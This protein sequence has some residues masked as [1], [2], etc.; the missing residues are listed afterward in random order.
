VQLY[1][2]KNSIQIHGGPVCCTTN[3]LPITPDLRLSTGNRLYQQLCDLVCLLSS[4]QTGT[5]LKFCKHAEPEYAWVARHTWQSWRE[6]YKKNAARLDI[7][8]EQLVE[9]NQP[10]Q[11]ENGQYGYVRQP[12]KRARRKRDLKQDDAAQA[13]RMTDPASSNGTE[14]SPS[15]DCAP[16]NAASGEPSQATEPNQTFE[17]EMDDPEWAI[18]VGQ[19]PPPIWAKRKAGSEA[20]D[21]RA[22]KKPRIA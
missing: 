20:D 3:N 4:V 16:G 7:L 11:G 13:G 8:I 22:G 12:E 6:R 19:A 1:R 15:Q 14:V 17:D 2:D 21:I 5:S 10:L 9:R 18:R